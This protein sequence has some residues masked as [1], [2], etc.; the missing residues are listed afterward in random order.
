M[1][2][3]EK[4][5]ATRPLAEYADEIG[6]EPVVLTSKDDPIAALVSIENADL[7]TI[8]LSTNPR[9]LDLIGRS[10]ARLRAEGGIPHEEMRRRFE[11]PMQ[12]K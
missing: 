9:F 12:N 10:Q 4:S 1:K 7:E 8:F 5:H 3:I 2:V 11:G 6:A